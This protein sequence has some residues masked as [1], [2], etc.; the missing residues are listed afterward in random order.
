[1]S[2][3]TKQQMID[4]FGQAEIEALTD[5]DGA[6]DAIVD[7]VLDPAI[8]RADAEINGY[9]ARVYSLPLATVPDVLTDWAADIAR[10]QLYT[11]RIPDH[12]KDRYQAVIARLKDVA[13]G[14]MSLGDQ[15]PADSQVSNSD[16][17]QFSGPARVFTRRS[18]TGL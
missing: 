12:V 8:G 4:R 18:L 14:R 6:A 15:T 3:V 1:M 2:Y 17:P 5:R 11:D 7:A 16:T 10:W 13:A 9:L